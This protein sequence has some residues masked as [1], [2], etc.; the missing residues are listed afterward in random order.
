MNLA[1]SIALTLVLSVLGAAL[2][3]FGAA[4]Y[5]MHRMRPATSLHELV[6]EKLHLTGAQRRQIEGIERSHAARQKVL[7][8]EMRAANASLAEAFQEQHAYTPKLQAA[9]DRSHQVMAEVQKETMVHVL[10]MRAVLTPQ[11]AAVF[12][13]TVVQSLTEDDR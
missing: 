2:G 4:E 13:G 5:V 10:A 7:E 1:R 8:A 9:I 11:Q 6:H 12:D 3:A